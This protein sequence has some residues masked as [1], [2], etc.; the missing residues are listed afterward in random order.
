MHIRNLDQN[1][2][3]LPNTFKFDKVCPLFV[4]FHSS[5]RT[6]VTQS[7]LVQNDKLIVQVNAIEPSRT[8]HSNTTKQSLFP[9][10]KSFCL[11]PAAF[12]KVVSDLE[13]T[14]HVVQSH[15]NSPRTTAYLASIL[16]QNTKIKKLM[17]FSAGHRKQ[18]YERY[19]Q[20]LG[21]KN[22][23]LHSNRLVD[24]PP[25]AAYLEEVVAVLATPPNS[26]SA[27]SDPVDL[28]IHGS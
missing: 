1:D 26:Y 6:L 12:G 4:I 18:E 17:A 25:D 3:L 28:V 11:G 27:V 20:K 16:S 2:T 24:S 15:V 8:P 7:H 9:Q 19:F 13:L 22:I 23:V 14:G 21:M 10:D 5:L